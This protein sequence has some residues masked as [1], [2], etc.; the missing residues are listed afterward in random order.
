[1]ASKFARDAQRAAVAASEARA[2]KA[3]KL[4]LALAWQALPSIL[5][6]EALAAIERGETGAMRTAIRKPPR[7]SVLPAIRAAQRAGWAAG[8]REGREAI[9][10]FDDGAR[11]Q[12]LAERA[13]LREKYR[14]T[15]PEMKQAREQAAAFLK[16]F[17]AHLRDQVAEEMATARGKP[18]PQ[19]A[20]R[21]SRDFLE[22]M[23]SGGDLS[24]EARRFVKGVESS[25]RDVLAT[26]LLEVDWAT[27]R[28]GE[29][30]AWKASDTVV[31]AEFSATMDDETTPACA[32]LDG[33]TML[34]TDRRV[35][36][37]N[38]GLHY[39][40]RSKLVARAGTRKEA[41]WDKRQTKII[42]EP[43]AGSDTQRGYTLRPS[44]IKVP[45]GAPNVPPPHHL[46]E[47]VG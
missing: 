44:Q 13:R 37:Y 46:A 42:G 20:F 22:T 12:V 2:A 19:R 36:S 3:A 38:P 9:E 34:S 45:A 28:R 7:S 24:P 15:G 41:T 1:M 18:D 17:T 43:S 11:A 31:L 40:C 33:E 26:P 4:A 47:W 8:I 29:V 14:A 39:R 35:D 21:D 27:A 23:R 5:T 30:A 6:D 32:F 16:S 10:V 25:A